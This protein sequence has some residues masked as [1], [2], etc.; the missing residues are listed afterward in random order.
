MI[1]SLGIRRMLV[2]AA[3]GSWSGLAA[4]GQTDPAVD[5]GAGTEQSGVK[6][7]TDTPSVH[8]QAPNDQAA[9]DQTPGSSDATDALTRRHTSSLGWYYSRGFYRDLSPT[10]V[11][12]LPFS[13]E[14][15]VNSWRFKTTL[16]WLE[17]D[18]PGNVLVNLG[19]VGQSNDWSEPGPVN[20]AGDVLVSAT[21]ELPLWSQNAPFVD[22]GVEVK[23]P[24]A[25]PKKGLGTGKTDVGL[26]V[27]LYQMLGQATAFVTLGYRYRRSSPYFEQL[28]NSWAASL[29]VSRALSDVMQAGVIYDYRQ[30]VSEF[31]EATHELL[32]Y[33]AWSPDPRWSVMLYVSRGFSDDSPDRVIGSQLSLRW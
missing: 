26:Q 20:G 25:D 17:V 23:L 15:A 7:Q 27:D 33:I 24:V 32:P 18:G 31:T 9:N 30:R 8:A 2:I 19:N 10:R 21:Y 16:A 14:T 4:A 12:Y 3:I 1:S 29:G 28:H 6:E 5:A 11:R 13:H 22:I